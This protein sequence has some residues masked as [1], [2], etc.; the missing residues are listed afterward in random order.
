MNRIN[1]LFINMMAISLI[2]SCSLPF[3]KVYNFNELELAWVTN[4]KSKRSIILY[5]DQSSDTINIS[6]IE[7]S[8]KKCVSIFDLKSANWLEGQ[9]EYHATASI[10][11]TLTHK[12]KAYPGIFIITKSNNDNVV[13]SFQIGDLYSQHISIDDS[14]NIIRFIDGINSEMGIN[15]EKVGIHQVEWDKN[16]GICKIIYNDGETYKV[17]L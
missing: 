1:C 8:N 3:V 11:I 13:V 14:V 16:K 9:N 4:M 7:V 5:S 6:S 10:S 15:Q 17:H 2:T 12:G